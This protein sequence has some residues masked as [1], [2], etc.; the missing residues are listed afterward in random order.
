MDEVNQCLYG[1]GLVDRKSWVLKPKDAIN[2]SYKKAD[3]LLAKSFSNW[4]ENKFLDMKVETRMYS[5]NKGQQDIAIE[6]EPLWHKACIQKHT[7]T[8]FKYASA[9]RYCRIDPTYYPTKCHYT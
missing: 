8:I 9:Q 1:F 7:I 2:L 4:N 3:F 5:F 6:Y